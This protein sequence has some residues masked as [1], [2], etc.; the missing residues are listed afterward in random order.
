LIRSLQANPTALAAWSRIRGI[1]P[2]AMPAYVRSLTPATLTGA[3]RVTNH[4][5]KNGKVKAF[6]SILPVGTAVLLDSARNVVARC[7]CGNPLLPAKPLAKK[8]TC[9]NCPK[10]FKPPALLPAGYAAPA[11]AVI[12]PPPVAG[13]GP[14]P[15]PSPSASPSP[16]ETAG[17][18]VNL[19]LGATAVASKTYSSKYPAKYGI[20]DL[21]STSWFSQ[22]PEK[23]T[24]TSTFTVTLAAPSTIDSVAFVDNSGNSDPSVRHGFGFRQ[25]RIYLIGSGGQLLYTVVPIKDPLVSQT[26]AVPSIA[27]VV[28]A[29]FVGSKHQDPTCGGFGAIWL[30][31]NHV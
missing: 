22:G 27:G 8:V 21:R 24:N 14:S 25:W 31:G 13:V 3:M 15:S 28:T 12:N 19:S 4:A 23:P 18:P 11:V 9:K 26:V 7:R 5:L 29:K 30:F 10:G 20:D 1:T 2:E 17:P 6:Q 16:T